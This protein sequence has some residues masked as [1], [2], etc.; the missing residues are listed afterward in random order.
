MLITE[1]HRSTMHMDTSES[2]LYDQV[3][4]RSVL[5]KICNDF[6]KYMDLV[7]SIPR[8]RNAGMLSPDPPAVF[9]I[10]YV[11]SDNLGG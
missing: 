3:D 2:P 6:F 7:L 4:T 8:Y 5:R 9:S 11:Q 10:P 1:R